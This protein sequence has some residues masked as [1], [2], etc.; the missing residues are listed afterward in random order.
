MW[1]P[2]ISDGPRSPD[3][4]SNLDGIDRLFLM[5]KLCNMP[6]SLTEKQRSAHQISIDFGQIDNAFE[7][8]GMPRERI[9]RPP[10]NQSV[11]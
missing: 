2:L 7:S 6:G 9:N 8:I 11:S 10:P 3:L 4:L 1:I 5:T